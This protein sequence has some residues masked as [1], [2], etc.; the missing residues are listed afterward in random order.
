MEIDSCYMSPDHKP[1]QYL[2]ETIVISMTLVMRG[3]QILLLDILTWV[4]KR[5]WDGKNQTVIS[6]GMSRW[7]LWGKLNG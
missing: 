6:S 7:I 3:C 4:L 2:C 5:L 1:S